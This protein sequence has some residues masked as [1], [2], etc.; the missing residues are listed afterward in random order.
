MAK[1][2]DKPNANEVWLYF[3]NVINWVKAVFPNYR[4]EMK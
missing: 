3:Q 4:K 2:Q 1:N